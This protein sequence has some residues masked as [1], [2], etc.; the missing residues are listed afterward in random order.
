[1][2]VSLDQPLRQDNEGDRM[3]LCDYNIKNESAIYLLHIL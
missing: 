1:M 2:F 3:R